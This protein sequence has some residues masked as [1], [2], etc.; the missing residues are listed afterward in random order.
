MLAEAGVAW[1][2]R[3]RRH[4]ALL[5]FFGPFIPVEILVPEA[6]ANAAQGALEPLRATSPVTGSRSA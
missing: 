2:A 3:A 4:R 5:Y 6:Q 1:H